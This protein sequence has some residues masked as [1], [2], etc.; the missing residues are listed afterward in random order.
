MKD[1]R[2]VCIAYNRVYDSSDLV[3][4]DRYPT[5]GSIWPCEYVKEILRQPTN[6]GEY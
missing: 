5:F 2:I 3:I 4:H 6:N 1:H